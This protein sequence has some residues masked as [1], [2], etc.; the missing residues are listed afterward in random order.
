MKKIIISIVLCIIFFSCSKYEPQQK[1]DWRKAG[2]THYEEWDSPTKDT[3]QID[4][5]KKLK[6]D[7]TKKNKSDFLGFY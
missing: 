4:T 3:I 5:T 2:K 1:E 6:S 7:T